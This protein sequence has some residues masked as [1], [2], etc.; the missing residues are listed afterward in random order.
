MCA[1][2]SA[3]P[4]REQLEHLLGRPGQHG[5]ITTHH[6]RS[7]QQLRTSFKRREYGVVVLERQLTRPGLLHPQ[8]IA[9][10]QTGLTQ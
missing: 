4:L 7:L 9:R 5:T 2:R 6:D 3:L 8:H 1:A 10:A